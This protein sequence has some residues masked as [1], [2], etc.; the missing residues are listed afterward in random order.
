MKVR[1]NEKELAAF[2]KLKDIAAVYSRTVDY[3]SKLHIA[4]YKAEGRPTSGTLDTPGLFAPKSEAIKKA[5]RDYNK[6]VDLMYRFRRKVG[7]KNWKRLHT[8]ELAGLL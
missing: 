2:R 1:T 6:A 4:A 8:L 3:Y 5:D 7:A